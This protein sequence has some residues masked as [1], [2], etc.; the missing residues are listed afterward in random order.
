M[1][2]TTIEKLQERK[3]FARAHGGTRLI[4]DYLPIQRIC[5]RGRP[6]QDLLGPI[7]SEEVVHLSIA[8]LVDQ[9]A[10]RFRRT[11]M[12]THVAMTIAP[13]VCILEVGDR[14]QV[15]TR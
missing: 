10:N 6:L 12:H 15:V 9:P 8:D 7:H 14:T 5:R 3:K 11:H 4:Y 2:D 1:N 13:R